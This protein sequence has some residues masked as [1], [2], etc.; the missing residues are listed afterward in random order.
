[1]RLDTLVSM[2]SKTGSITKYFST[3][4][5]RQIFRG[6]MLVQH[7]LFAM[8]FE[9][10]AVVTQFAHPPLNNIAFLITNIGE[11]HLAEHTWNVV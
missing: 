7:M 3:I 1:M 6:C 4:F 8:M 9:S 2:L 10:S 11:E 5:T